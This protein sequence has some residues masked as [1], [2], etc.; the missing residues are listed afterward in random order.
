MSRFVSLCKQRNTSGRLNRGVNWLDNEC[1]CWGFENVEVKLAQ[2]VALTGGIGCG[3]RDEVDSVARLKSL[4][5]G[6]DKQG[7]NTEKSE[8]TSI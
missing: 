7:K 5:E 3:F 4:Y 2:N 1:D 8:R 6:H